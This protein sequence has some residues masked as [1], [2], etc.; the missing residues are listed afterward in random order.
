MDVAAEAGFDLVDRDPGRVRRP[1]E[2]FAVVVTAFGSVGAQERHGAAVRL[3]DRDVVVVDYGLELAVRRFLGLHCIDVRGWPHRAGKASAA[4]TAA[5]AASGFRAP[6]RVGIQ[7]APPRARIR[8][9]AGCTWRRHDGEL[10][11]LLVIDEG[12]RV[13]RQVEWGY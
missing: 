2:R 5:S 10:D 3:A 13:E 4:A 6:A 8:W 11:G 9:R 12:E 7:R 1:F